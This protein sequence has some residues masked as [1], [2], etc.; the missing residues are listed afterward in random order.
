MPAGI[1]RVAA[2]CAPVP[3]HKYA[4]LSCVCKILQLDKMKGA[5]HTDALIFSR[6]SLGL[7]RFRIVPTKALKQ[8][9][10]WADKRSVLAGN[11]ETMKRLSLLVATLAT[12]VLSPILASSQ[13]A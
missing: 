10:V 6:F 12:L 5:S 7:G 11:G 9:S 1:K 3:P 4:S 13:S 2:R 8:R